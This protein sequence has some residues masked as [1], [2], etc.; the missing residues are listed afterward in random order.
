[1]SDAPRLPAGPVAYLTGQYPK[2]SHTF[3]QR[4]VAALRKLGVTVLTCQVRRAAPAEIAPDQTA[5]AAATFTILDAARAP[6]RLAAAHLSLIARAP[7]RWLGALRLAWRTRA[8][9]LRA[10]LYQLFYFA[11]AG[12]LAAHLRA[13]G[14]VHL[15]NHFADSSG[16]VAM[17]A[18]DLADLPYSFTEHGPTIFTAPERWRLDTKIAR[19]RF[20]VAIS[21]FCRS[22][23]MLHSDPAHWLRLQIVR[24]G[25]EPA[26]YD[27]PAR[28]GPV[29]RLIFIGRLARVKGVPLL[30]DALARLAPDHPDLRLTLVGDGP[31]RVSLQAEAEALGL[32]ERV[33]F[34]GL[35]C[36][37]E[38]A[39]ALAA[40]DALVLPSF[41]EGLPVVLMEALA[42]RLPVVATQVAGIPELVRDGE[43]G[44]LVPP[45]DAEALAAAIARLLADPDL[46]RRMGE[47]G[48]A[49]VLA[50]HDIDREAARLA[51]L[52]AG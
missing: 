37:A 41:A 31:D 50:E 17:L 28:S 27:T 2:M 15:H 33:Q 9:G 44:L 34:T 21:R 30:L 32:A 39:E 6:H 8:P 45:G 52:F 11:E 25:I 51:A 22:Q 18:A 3:I 23:L 24:C 16:T 26:R 19:A 40:H 49:R 36:A 46:C 10:G 7:G 48:R 35:L 38:V 1:M 12:V 13:A 42:S 29:R 43:T 4:E 47:A 14:A 5:E 20:V